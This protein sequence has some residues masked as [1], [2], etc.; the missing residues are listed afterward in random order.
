MA[1]LR[2]KQTQVVEQ[3]H[4]IEDVTDMMDEEDEYQWAK[5]SYQNQYNHKMLL[6]IKSKHGIEPRYT[7][8]T[9]DPPYEKGTNKMMCF[10]FK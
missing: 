10:L 7:E 9:D 4:T 5:S 6:P 2:N 8:I 3:E 1:Q